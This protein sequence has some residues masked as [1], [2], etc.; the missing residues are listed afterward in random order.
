[1]MHTN[2]LPFTYHIENLLRNTM[3]FTCDTLPEKIIEW[4]EGLSKVN[5]QKNDANFNTR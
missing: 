4:K 1:M 5:T 3:I 2:K